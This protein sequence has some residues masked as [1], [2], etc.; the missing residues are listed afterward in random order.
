MIRRILAAFALLFAVSAHAQLTPPQ[1]ATLKAA[2]TANPTCAAM[3]ASQ[4]PDDIAIAAWFNAADD[5]NCIVWRPDVSI[6]EANAV[7]VWTEVDALAVGKARI[8]EWMRLVPVL[9]YRQSS[10]RQGINDAFAGTST[11]TAVT[12]VG[13]RTATRAER[14]LATG[15]CTNVSPSFMTWFGPISY[16]DA[17]QIR[18]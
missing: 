14:A 3:A 5:G 6:A 2:C 8:W 11:R 16:A 9:D 4:S 1:I 17:S 13:K 12:Q 7:M 18:S 10:L 15:A